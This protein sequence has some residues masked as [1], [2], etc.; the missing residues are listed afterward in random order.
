MTAG[1]RALPRQP[2]QPQ[3]LVRRIAFGRRGDSIL[4]PI[5]EA[6]WVG[7]ETG[8]GTVG[9]RDEG[10]GRNAGVKGERAK[11]DRPGAAKDV[12]RRSTCLSYFTLASE[13]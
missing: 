6:K 1:G 11:A 3:L 12:E 13:K 8:V 4:P 7:D 2:G 5:G 9:I 10:D